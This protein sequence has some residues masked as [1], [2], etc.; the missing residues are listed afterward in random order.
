[1]RRQKEIESVCLCL[2]FVAADRVEIEEGGGLRGRGE[3]VD[4]GSLLNFDAQ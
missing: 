4:E 3:G 2:L 1:M